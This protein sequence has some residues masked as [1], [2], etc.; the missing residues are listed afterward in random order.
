MNDHVTG[1]QFKNSGV[2]WNDLVTGCQFKNSGVSW[3]SLFLNMS[4]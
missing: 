2:S 1:C 3:N 4:P